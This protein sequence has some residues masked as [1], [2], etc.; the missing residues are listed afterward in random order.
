[1]ALSELPALPMQG[2]Q[3]TPDSQPSNSLATGLKKGQ[4]FP[5]RGR[6]VP[7]SIMQDPESTGDIVDD[8]HAQEEHAKAIASTAEVSV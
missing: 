7:V 2:S 8:V 1:M 3:V 4:F 5:A 6:A